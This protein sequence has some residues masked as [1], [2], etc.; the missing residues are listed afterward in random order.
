[1]HSASVKHLKVFILPS[2]FLH[3]K[4]LLIF[5]LKILF[6]RPGNA[7]VV[8]PSEVSVHTAKV[9]ETLLPLYIDKVRKYPI[10]SVFYDCLSSRGCST[11]GE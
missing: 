4:I 6:S 2:I 11:K 1:M 9:M 8:K 3:C 7:A 5:S 10:T